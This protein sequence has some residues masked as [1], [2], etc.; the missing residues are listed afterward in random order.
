MN[1]YLKRMKT[2]LNAS[3]VRALTKKRT[4]LLKEQEN[5]VDAGERAEIGE[6]IRAIEQDLDRAREIVN[7]E[8]ERAREHYGQ[9]V[10]KLLGRE[11]RRKRPE[12]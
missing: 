6:Q 4:A 8:V 3:L 10:R 9:V 1:D 11:R 2:A 12:R 5:A 7:R